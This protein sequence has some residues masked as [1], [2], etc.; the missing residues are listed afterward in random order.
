MTTPSRSASSASRERGAATVIL[1]LF[2]LVMVAFALLVAL[3]MGASDITDSAAHNDATE[4]LFLAESGI[5]RAAKRF[6]DGTPCTTAALA[7]SVAFGRGTFT[8][9][10]AVFTANICRVRV[11]GEVRAAKRVVL[12]DASTLLYEPFPDKYSVPAVLDAAWPET[13]IKKDGKS[14][15]DTASATAD[16]TGSLIMQTKRGRNDKFEAYRRRT[17]PAAITGPQTVTLNLAYKMNYAGAPPSNQQLQVRL[18]D[19]AGV[20]RLVPGA[21]FNGPSNANVWIASPTL[22]DTIAAGVTITRIELYYKLTN[23]NSKDA[24]TFIWAD[25]VR[26]TTS[27]AAFPLKAWTEIIQ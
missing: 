20:A 5:E 1:A 11:R 14:G 25:N 13:I 19:S 16:A 9:L 26:L 21:D 15:Y 8:L 4:A 6:A 23:G 18:V 10:E 3:N 22:T 12:G 2:L 27:A 24:Q 17:L 7:E